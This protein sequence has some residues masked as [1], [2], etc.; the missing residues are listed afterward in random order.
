MQPEVYCTHPNWKNAFGK[1]NNNTIQ[2]T[3]KNI[4]CKQAGK[5]YIKGN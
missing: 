4:I 3:H 2:N 1:N 5:L